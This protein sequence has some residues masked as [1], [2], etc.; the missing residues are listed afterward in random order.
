MKG[1]ELFNIEKELCKV[2]TLELSKYIVEIINN[3]DDNIVVNFHSKIVVNFHSKNANFFTEL[4]SSKKMNLISNSTEDFSNY[5]GGF[6]NHDNFTINILFTEINFELLYT[7]LH[8]YGHFISIKNNGI[9]NDIVED[10]KNRIISDIVFEDEINAWNNAEEWINS[11]QVF[12]KQVH[13]CSRYKQYKNSKLKEYSHSKY[14]IYIIKEMLSFPDVRF[15]DDFE[16]NKIENI[17][18]KIK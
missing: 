16:K 1:L 10:R 14:I 7:I 12:N 5:G 8:E 9:N 18:E 6:F 11:N 3:F 2:D 17:L 4:N 13:F 15:I